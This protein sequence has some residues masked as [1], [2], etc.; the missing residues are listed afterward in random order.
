MDRDKRHAGR[1]IRKAR[2]I[3]RDCERAFLNLEAAFGNLGS[4]AHESAQRF[5]TF[6]DAYRLAFGNW[7]QTT[8]TFIPTYRTDHA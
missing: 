8:S 3:R 1:R 4:A 2:R 5:A 6:E 7:Y